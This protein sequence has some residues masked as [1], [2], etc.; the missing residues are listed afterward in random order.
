MEP[1]NKQKCGMVMYPQFVPPI[2]YD[3]RPPSYEYDRR[4]PSY[5]YDRK[6]SSYEYDRKLPSYET[7]YDPYLDHQQHNLPIM[8]QQEEEEDYYTQQYRILNRY[9]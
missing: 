3:R 5:E 7:G 4:P 1:T 9:L 8:N 6:L 2:G